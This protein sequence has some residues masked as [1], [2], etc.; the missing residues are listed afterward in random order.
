M[1]EDDGVSSA[2]GFSD[3]GNASLVGFGEDASSRQG[4]TMTGGPTGFA[5]QQGT[6]RGPGSPMQGVEKAKMLD[7]Q[8]Y[9]RDGA[10]VDTT[11]RNPVP[12]GHHAQIYGHAEDGEDGKG[13]KGGL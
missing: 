4:G 12:I 1:S 13:K 2:G 3:Q 5:G 11:T 9:D 7:G 6:I 10:F 8:T